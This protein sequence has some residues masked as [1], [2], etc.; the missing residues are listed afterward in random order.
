MD[1]STSITR[2]ARNVILVGEAGSGKTSIINMIAGSTVAP[3]SEVSGTRSCA[4]YP[5]EIGGLDY[6]IYDTPGVAGLRPDPVTKLVDSLRDGV[7]LLVFCL[8][9]RIT[10]DAVAIYQ[11][12]SQRL[13][14]VPVVIVITGLEHEDPMESWWTKNEAIFDGYRM[15]FN[16]H[17]C[18]TTVRGKGSIFASQYEESAVAVRDL[19][20]KHCL[21]DGQRAESQRYQETAAIATHPI[22]RWLHR[23][24][25]H[26][27]YRWRYIVLLA[28]VCIF[29]IVVVVAVEASR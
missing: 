12:V 20:T 26:W 14:G 17:A 27:L 22:H 18:V 5:M 1:T 10:E 13:K 8:R 21:K 7:S 2:P 9:G 25:Y 3:I 28:A 16:G 4:A 19:I 11:H 24:H 15:S 23:W 6:D 29:I